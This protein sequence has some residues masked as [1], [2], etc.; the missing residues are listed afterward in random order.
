MAN[1][2]K[3]LKARK[4]DLVAY[5]YESSFTHAKGKTESRTYWA[6][7]V[8][9]K[10]DKEGTIKKVVRIADCLR[11]KPATH[12][13]PQNVRLHVLVFEAL[14]IGWDALQQRFPWG[15]DNFESLE[16]VRKAIKPI[17]DSSRAEAQKR[18]MA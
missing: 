15:E 13:A 1:L 4:W 3:S 9:W 16:D 18:V 10:C 7:R 12:D 8:V 14:T 2:A 6:L 5:P 11:E 17:M